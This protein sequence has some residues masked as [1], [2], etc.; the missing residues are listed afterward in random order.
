MSFPIG[1]PFERSLS[2]AEILRYKRI[3]VTSLTFEGQLTSSF[4]SP[5]VI[6]YW[7]AFGTKSVSP[8]DFQILRSKHIGVTSLA[9]ISNGFRDI[10]RQM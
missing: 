4:D 5:Y 6:S 3:G 10:Q 8:D 7:W 9:T 2:P 1:G